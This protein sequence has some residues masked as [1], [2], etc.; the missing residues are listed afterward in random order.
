[1]GKR[2]AYL[3]GM[4]IAILAGI[5]FYTNHCNCCDGGGVENTTINE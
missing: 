4:V 1:M 5:Y 2:L 3:I